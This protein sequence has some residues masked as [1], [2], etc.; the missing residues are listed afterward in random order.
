MAEM[1]IDIFTPHLDALHK[2]AV[3]FSF[4][5]II[6]LNGFGKTW[7]SGPGIEL[8]NRT[9]QRFSRNDI[10]IN[11]YFLIIPVFILKWWLSTV[12]LGHLILQRRQFLFQGRIVRL[13][14]RP[15]ILRFGDLQ[16]L[17]PLL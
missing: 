14:I 8:V 11:S 5:D 12:L 6:R 9:E 17:P 16:L 2:N 4:Y 10:D 13:L 15:L 3:I 7:P 1:G